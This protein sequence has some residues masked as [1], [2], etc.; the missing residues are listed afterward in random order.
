M[1]G[2]ELGLGA[3]AIALLVL[4]F[5]ALA[6]WRRAA[7]WADPA[8]QP[9]AYEIG[10]HLAEMVRSHGEIT[11][12]VQGLMHRIEGFD[13]RLNQSMTETANRTGEVLS[14][15]SERISLIDVAQKNIEKLSS[16]TV[17]LQQVLANKQ[18]RGAFGEGRMEAII[19]D[20]LP[21]NAYAFH[22]PLKNGT[23]PDC[24]VKMPDGGPSLAIDAKFPL[25]AWTAIRSATTPEA[26]KAAEAQFRRDVL[27]H[28]QDIAQRYLVPGET[29]DTAFMFVP[30]ESI[31][32]D[33]YE[34]YDDII[35][36]AHRS[37]VVIVSPSLLMLSI[38]VVMSL[39]RDQRMREQAHIIQDE[40]MRLMDDVGRLDQRVRNLRS[41]FDQANDDVRQ[42]L[43]ST[44][45]IAERR[46][47]IEVVEFDAAEETPA[48]ASGPEENPGGGSPELPFGRASGS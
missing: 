35:Q 40:V 46:G 38:Q 19:R 11:A 48:G 41:H 26:A 34:R 24:V 13:H 29:F 12:H 44:D 45:K 31:F 32:A 37:R 18:T 27:K 6:A 4:L 47:R 36:R 5:L 43:I 3:V 30:S 33:I 20:N 21:P 7:R 23:K 1:T 15:L 28:V 25:E 8:G 9:R 2:T 16:Q 17:Q 22:A 39:L 42:I 14:R 10:A